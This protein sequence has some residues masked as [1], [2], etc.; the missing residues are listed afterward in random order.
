MNLDKYIEFK[1]IQIGQVFVDAEGFTYEKVTTLT[2]RH[3]DQRYTA[4]Y[5]DYEFDAEDRLRVQPAPE[6]HEYAFDVKLFAVVRV[7]APDLQSA[8]TT[9]TAVIDAMEPCSDWI[10]GFNGNSA[11]RL[12]EVSL[13]E[14]G[15][16][17]NRRPFE[18]DGED[19]E[20]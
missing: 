13:A 9:M 6:T 7:V 17:E 19:V 16:G 1:D 11:C 4:G 15:E 10:A 12:T 18:I 2:A 3:R 5:L 14:D 20:D 8:I